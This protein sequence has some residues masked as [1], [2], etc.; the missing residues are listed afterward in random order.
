MKVK[1]NIYT[2]HTPDTL[3]ESRKTFEA[4]TKNRQEK[5]DKELKLQRQNDSLCKQFATVADP[6]SKWIS[7]QKDVITKS[8]KDLDEQLKFVNERLGSL[9]KDGSKMKE[10]KEAND[11]VEA[12][13][14]AN[15][16][17]TTLTF[18]DL[19]VQWA[20][21]KEFLNVKKKMLEDEIA[22][23]KMKGITA[24]QFQEIE[25]NFH[26]FDENKNGRIERKELKA[27]LYSL[28]EE[29]S[30]GE[31]DDIIKKF[32]QGG[33]LPFEGFKEFMIGVLGDSDTKDEI[34]NGFKLINRGA[35]SVTTVANL[36]M[37]NM[38]DE[39]VAYIKKTSPQAEGGYNYV[40]WTNDVFSR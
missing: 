10:I 16:K 3:G 27:C 14:I 11:K 13:G 6:F 36:E 21:F 34:L 9:E 12:A 30:K 15:N 25:T 32:G 1:E 35:D 29:K 28:G 8:Q 24:E 39:D 7:E 31:V 2:Q 19:E 40:A 17:H 5:Y 18:K 20:Q 22:Y 26:K 23:Q 33:S 38:S 37:V 4:S